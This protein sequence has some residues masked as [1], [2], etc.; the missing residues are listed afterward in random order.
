MRAAHCIERDGPYCLQFLQ[1]D[2]VGNGQDLSTVVFYRQVTEEDSCEWTVDLPGRA[3][4]WALVTAIPDVNQTEPILRVSG[5]SCDVEWES[6]FPSVYG[7]ENDILLLSQSFDDRALKND[8]MPPAGTDLL[9][10]T[11]SKD[12]VSCRVTLLHCQMADYTSLIFLAFNILI[13]STYSHSQFIYS[14]GWIPFW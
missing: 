8:F 12:E 10:W 2:E 14:Q 1:G 4:A 5:T 11:N 6:V 7:E 9:N 13:H 3:M